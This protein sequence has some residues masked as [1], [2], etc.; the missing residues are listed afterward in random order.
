MPE[1]D[2][3]V[4]KVVSRL[5][6]EAVKAPAAPAAPAAES[7]STS[8]SADV[9]AADY[10]ILQKH[11][12]WVKTPDGRPVASIDLSTIQRGEVENK[13]IRISRE[14]LLT[15]AK[16]AE[17]AGKPQVAE[18]FRRAAE[19]TGVPD[20]LV[21]QMYDKLRPNRATH[22]ELLGMADTLE[23]RYQAARCAKLVREAAE[24]YQKRGILLK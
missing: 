12:D 23:N 3:I 15:Q 24:I 11:P 9:T 6:E 16:V 13:D 2:E 18:N 4:R 20:E 22:E 21:I 1:M 7:K 10:P 5:A 8:A 14:M 19:M 17:S